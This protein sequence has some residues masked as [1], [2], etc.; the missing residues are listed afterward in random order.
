[1][2]PGRWVNYQGKKTRWEDH[3]DR[4]PILSVCGIQA[5][6]VCWRGLEG[7]GRRDWELP[8]IEVGECREAGGSKYLKYWRF[9]KLDRR[10]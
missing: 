3:V 8:D 10:R 6:K 7:G 5:F 4:A 9:V 2:R 1:M